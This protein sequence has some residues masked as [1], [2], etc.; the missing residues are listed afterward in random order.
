MS[1]VPMHEEAN[2]LLAAL[3]LLPTFSTSEMLKAFE[4][5]PGLDFDNR[6]PSEEELEEYERYSVAVPSSPTVDRLNLDISWLDPEEA[7]ALFKG[8]EVLLDYFR[9]KWNDRRSNS[10]GG[11]RPP[12]D[13]GGSGPQ[14]FCK[15]LVEG[16]ECGHSF[17]QPLT[18]RKGKSITVIRYCTRESVSHPTVEYFTQDS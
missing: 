18:F 13:F 15:H 5:M 10:G 1:Q 9:K 8:L 14:E 11:E 4:E 7:I 6:L 3:L 2:T 17:Q 12:V 16:Q